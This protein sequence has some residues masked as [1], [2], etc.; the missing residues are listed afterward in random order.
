MKK[1]KLDFF[2]RK[3]KTQQT[4]RNKKLGASIGSFLVFFIEVEGKYL[5]KMVEQQTK[6]RDLEMS[7]KY[8]NY[9]DFLS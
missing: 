1:V 6:K 5:L 3:K 7:I 9:E 2:S 4:E 8:L